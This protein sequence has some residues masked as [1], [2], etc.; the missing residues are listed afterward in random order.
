L[1]EPEEVPVE[2][3]KRKLWKVVVLVIVLVILIPVLVYVY[4]YVVLD[5]AYSKSWDTIE[6]SDSSSPDMRAHGR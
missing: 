1:S 2:K 4:G 6:I 5:D 3:P